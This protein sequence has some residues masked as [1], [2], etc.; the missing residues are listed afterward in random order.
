MTLF[1]FVLLLAMSIAGYIWNR[2][3][4]AA[5]RAGGGRL[6]SLSGFHGMYAF[7]CRSFRFSC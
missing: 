6:H 3:A 7:L 4:A 2:Q 5:L 1:A